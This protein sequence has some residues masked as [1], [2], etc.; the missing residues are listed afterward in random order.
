MDAETLISMQAQ[1]I[2]LLKGTIAA[3][4]ER[5]KKAG[6][7]CGVP[8]E[9]HGCDWPD[10]MAEQVLSQAARIA[11]LEA[12]GPKCAAIRS[13]AILMA[14]SE[15]GTPEFEL[16]SKAL[17]AVEADVEVILKGGA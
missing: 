17:A 10:W 7:R 1:E 9:Q 16:W 3:Q 15:P 4:D 12:L 11:Q 2:A 5:E 14:M 6:E 8:C 13:A